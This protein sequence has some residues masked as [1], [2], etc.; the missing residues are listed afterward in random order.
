MQFFRTALRGWELQRAEMYGSP[1]KK[2][3]LRPEYMETF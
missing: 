1:Q 3:I 2:L